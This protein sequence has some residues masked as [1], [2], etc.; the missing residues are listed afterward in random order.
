[1]SE[2]VYVGIDVAKRTFEVATTGQAQTFSLGNDE[3]GHAQLCQLL[4]PLS[5]RLVL[6][7]ATG[8]YEQDLAL[9]LSAAGLRV[10]VI[11]PRQA[12]DFARCMGKLAKTDRI[13]AQA[14]RGFA[15]L[16][17]AQGHEPRMLADEQQRELT[18]L[19]VRRRQLV[20]MLVAE[21]QRLALA[22]PKAKP[23]I[24]RIM[25]TIAEQLNDLDGQLKEHVLA[26]HADLAALLTSVKGVGPTTASTLLAQLP[27]LGQL[28]R[29]QI[30]SLVGLAP[31]NRDSGTL[32]GQRH[33]FGGR[34]DVRRVL[35][36][37]ALVGTRFN[38]VLKAFYARLL[39]AGK[40]KKVALVACM[41]KLLV[42]LNAIARTK[43]PWRNELAEAV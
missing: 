13:D 36:V 5:P 24:L 6:L 14:L 31:I 11:N 17:D 35:F 43:S 41:H 40:P 15:A 19:V 7:E 28:N 9:A 30:T 39:A 8:G 18:A 4:A 26:H 25:A 2:P 1:M 37:A 29:K 32:R 42:I 34:A 38:P 23:S 20:A 33:I 16:L 22:H 3:A 12:R 27:E 10:S 21:R